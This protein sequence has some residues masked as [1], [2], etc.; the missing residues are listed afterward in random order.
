[1]V[2]VDSFIW[3][4]MKNLE[5]SSNPLKA[6]VKKMITEKLSASEAKETFDS[7]FRKFSRNF[8]LSMQLLREAGVDL[9][10]DVV[11]SSHSYIPAHLKTNLT[12][13]MFGKS[14]NILEVN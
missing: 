4:H 3:S 9:E 7:D 12:I 5:K 1:M 8:D 2:L 13:N 10:S 11:F 6:D 14:V